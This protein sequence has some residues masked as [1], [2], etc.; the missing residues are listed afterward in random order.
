MDI[1][2]I[3]KSY[4][5]K[6]ALPLVVVTLIVES[7]FIPDSY[8]G[9]KLTATVKAGSAERYL[10]ERGGLRESSSRGG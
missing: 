5:Y 7:A 2:G 6:F 8:I 10:M 4:F 3:L 1:T 9:K